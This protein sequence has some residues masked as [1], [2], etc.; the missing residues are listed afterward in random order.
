MHV[1][2]SLTRK[3]DPSSAK[4]NPSI[5]RISA[6]LSICFVTGDA[7]WK[8]IRT[9][10]FG[11]FPSD[12]TA[13]CLPASQ[14]VCLYAVFGFESFFYGLV[15]GRFRCLAANGAMERDEAEGELRGQLVGYEMDGWMDGYKHS[16]TWAGW[17][18]DVCMD[19][20][21]HV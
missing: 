6:R 13:T 10:G 17:E 11:I 8:R 9:R 7:S 3:V 1:Y 20:H 19:V 18:M 21:A 15:S 14:P 4:T 16:L 2:V 5:R 12:T